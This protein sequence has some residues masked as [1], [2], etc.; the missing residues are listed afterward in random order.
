MPLLSAYEI[1]QT[2]LRGPAAI[3]RL[4]EQT[5]GTLA[6]YGPP[7]PDLQQRTIEAQSAEI[8]CLQARLLRLEAEVTR[9]RYHNRQL[10]SQIAQAQALPGSG[11]IVCCWLLKSAILLSQIIKQHTIAPPLIPIAATFQEK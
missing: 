2:Y 3:I 8:D 4:F 1:Y 10:I 7:E 6:L 9:L 11:V 5:F